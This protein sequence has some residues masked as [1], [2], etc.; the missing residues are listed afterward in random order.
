MTP[1]RMKYIVLLCGL[2]GDD[3]ISHAT[4]AGVKD[5]LRG[6]ARDMDSQWLKKPREGFPRLLQFDSLGNVVYNAGVN[7]TD[8]TFAVEGKVY[9]F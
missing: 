3:N 7:M 4:L 2:D 9:K 6:I 5:D 1:K 8:R